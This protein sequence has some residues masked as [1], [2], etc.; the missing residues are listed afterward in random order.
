MFSEFS[1]KAQPRRKR[2]LWKKLSVSTQVCDSLPMQAS[3]TYRNYVKHV[4]T[5]IRLALLAFHLYNLSGNKVTNTKISRHIP[6]NLNKFTSMTSYSPP[7]ISSHPFYTAFFFIE[8]AFLVWKSI[9]T[10]GSSVSGHWPGQKKLTTYRGVTGGGG[11]YSLIGYR[12]FSL[13]LIRA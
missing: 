10:A 12:F 6:V 9:K 13:C 8:E 3:S 11:G 4:L 7:S 5:I 1:F 2:S